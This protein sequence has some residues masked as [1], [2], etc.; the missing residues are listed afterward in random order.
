MK[1]G[2]VQ[3]H[4]AALV[5]CW[6]SLKQS[7]IAIIRTSSKV[8]TLRSI[9]TYKQYRQS[10][11]CYHPNS[12]FSTTTMDSTASLLAELPSTLSSTTGS[13]RPSSPTIPTVATDRAIA[14][15]LARKL[16]LEKRK[17][18][19]EAKKETARLARE[20]AER[21]KAPVVPPFRV[22][23]WVDVPP[24]EGEVVGKGKNVSIFS[25]NVSWCSRADSMS[26]LERL[27]ACCVPRCWLRLWLR[28]I[29]FPIQTFSSR[30]IEYQPS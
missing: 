21:N 27:I 8:S 7:R 12:H 5:N 6:T 9:I 29:S 4:A 22:R 17:G 10:Q 30:K 1:G 18:D 25:W 3:L 15:E 28:E 16:M 11:P 2:K 26:Q 13:P 19:K 20:E 14:A 24:A 23:Q